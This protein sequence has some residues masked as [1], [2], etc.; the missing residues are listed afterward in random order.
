MSNQLDMFG[1]PP[2]SA[3]GLRDEALHRV[4]SNN[5]EWMALALRQ[6]KSLRSQMS[7]FTGEE[8]RLRLETRI[9]KPHHHNAMGALVKQALKLGLIER[10]GQ[11]RAMMEPKSHAR[12]TAVYRAAN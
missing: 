12:M 7:S 2:L 1:G 3:K 11:F 4:S 9:G 6:I 10:T 8:L 5:E